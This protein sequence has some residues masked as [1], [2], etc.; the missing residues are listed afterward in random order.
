MKSNGRKVNIIRNYQKMID[1]FHH[2]LWN[3]PEFGNNYHFVIFEID[4]KSGAGQEI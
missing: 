1:D 3:Y 2:F 4:T